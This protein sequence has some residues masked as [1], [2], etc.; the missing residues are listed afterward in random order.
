MITAITIDL[1]RRLCRHEGVR[2]H[3]YRC[4]S[5]KLTIGVGRN[6]DDKGLSRKEALYLLDNDLRRVELE[7]AQTFDWFD[8]LDDVRK[9]VLIEMA[10]NLGIT[11][12]TKFRKMLAAVKAGNF[13]QARLEMLNSLWAKQVGRRADTLAHI[14]ETGKEK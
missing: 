6:L 2:L 3:P 9:R 11:G 13:E 5:G 10:F 8:R 4:T 7:C 12:L 1:K 14:M